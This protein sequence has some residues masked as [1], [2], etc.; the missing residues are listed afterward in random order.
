MTFH[1]SLFT[2]NEDNGREY[3]GSDEIKNEIN[4]LETGLFYPH[5]L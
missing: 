4:C 2:G 5:W 3:E 1:P